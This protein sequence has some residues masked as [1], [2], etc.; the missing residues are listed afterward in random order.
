MAV[1]SYILERFKYNS[2]FLDDF[3]SA[4][5]SPQGTDTNILIGVSDVL[6]HIS[7]GNIHQLCPRDFPAALLVEQLKNMQVDIPLSFNILYFRMLMSLNRI[8][9]MHKI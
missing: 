1:L 8:S 2:F 9:K 3:Q 5:R 4:Y 6:D 7:K